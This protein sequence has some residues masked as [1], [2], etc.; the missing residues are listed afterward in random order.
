[1]KLRPATIL[2]LMRL[3]ESTNAAEAESAHA[4]LARAQVYAFTVPTGNGDVWLLRLL[5]SLG[6][7]VGVVVWQR[8]A[9]AVVVA[10]DEHLLLA[11]LWFLATL[12]AELSAATQSLGG[13]ARDMAAWSLAEAVARRFTLD[14][15]RPLITPAPASSVGEEE[16]E[17]LRQGAIAGRWIARDVTP[18]RRTIPL[19][20]PAHREP[21]ILDLGAWSYSP[22]SQR[23]LD[24]LLA[25]KLRRR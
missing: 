14:L 21:I 15:E 20:L 11:A 25:F 18:L 8:P 13:A 7:D 5:S 19:R 10:P 9:S 1:V 23:E 16:R 17:R 2:H 6:R 12:R 22:L 3:R 24:L 4:T